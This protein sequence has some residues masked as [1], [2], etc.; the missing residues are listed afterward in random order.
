MG[1]EGPE[2]LRDLDSW[3]QEPR[4]TLGTVGNRE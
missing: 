1:T 4:T 2:A 3:T